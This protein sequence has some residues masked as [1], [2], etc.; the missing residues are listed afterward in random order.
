MSLLKQSTSDIIDQAAKGAPAVAG[1]YASAVTLSEW[2][3]ILTGMYVL[4]QMVYLV[5]KWTW[6]RR[7]KQEA[8][9]RLIRQEAR[10]ERQLL[11]A[12]AREALRKAEESS[13]VAALVEP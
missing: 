11:A 2:V 10:E 12:E 1:V 8:F 7:E 4:I 13:R 5:W 6:E 9:A 3:A